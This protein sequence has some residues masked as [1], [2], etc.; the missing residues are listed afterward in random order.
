LRMSKLPSFLRSALSASLRAKI[1]AAV[2]L[3]VFRL[4]D[5]HHFGLGQPFPRG[6]SRSRAQ[7]RRNLPV[8]NQSR[9]TL[10]RDDPMSGVSHVGRIL[11]SDPALWRRPNS[12][13]IEQRCFRGNVSG[14]KVSAFRIDPRIRQVYW[15]GRLCRVCHNRVDR[16]VGAKCKSGVCAL[17][18]PE[19]VVG[20]LERLQAPALGGPAT[21][22]RDPPQRPQDCRHA[23][24]R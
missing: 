23:G 11:Q 22:P 12:I 3:R 16:D 24:A 8:G 21:A 1:L 18:V 20:S 14:R 9:L 6:S 4:A 2:S 15:W 5:S 17:R 13:A 10:R 7:C 19:V